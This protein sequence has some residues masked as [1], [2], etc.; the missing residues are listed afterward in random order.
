MKSKY[1]F[2]ILIAS[3]LLFACG[4]PVDLTDKI[5]LKGYSD[6][7][8]LYGIIDNNPNTQDTVV[9][10]LT[11]ALKNNGAYTIFDNAIVVLTD[12]RG[13]IDTLDYY[14]DG[15]YLTKPGFAGVPD[16]RNYNLTIQVEGNTFTANSVMPT[17]R[18]GIPADQVIDSLTYYYQEAQGFKEAG[19]YLKVYTKDPPNEL[20]YYLF[21][22]FKNDTLMSAPRGNKPAEIM[23]ADD[24]IVASDIRGIELPYRFELGNN[25][26][27]VIYSLTLDGYNY[28]TG[29]NQQ[30]NNSGGLFSTPPANTLGNFNNGALGFFQVSSYADKSIVI[31]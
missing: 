19:Y 21:K 12:N 28:Y 1:L 16:G 7:Y 10:S 18:E 24:K 29:L 5:N 14:K 15:K 8:V 20:N 26:K 23:V 4:K 9:V 3:Q 31:K 27:M 22:I 30:I 13:Y 11:K 25:V 2:L 6:K 17:L